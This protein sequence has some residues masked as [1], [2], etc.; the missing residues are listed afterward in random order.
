MDIDT[1][2]K[3]DPILK[4]RA[5]PDLIEIKF[6]E[7]GELRYFT[8]SEASASIDTLSDI[9]YVWMDMTFEKSQNISFDKDSL[10]ISQ[11]SIKLDS[12]PIIPFVEDT[13]EKPERGSWSCFIIRNP[14]LTAD[15]LYSGMGRNITRVSFILD[16]NRKEMDAFIYGSLIKKQSS[17]TSFFRATLKFQY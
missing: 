5:I 1:P 3:E 16:K 2:T 8:V 13:L 4:D 6:D 12:L 10:Y 11:F 7:N 14:G 17:D 9:P 15:T